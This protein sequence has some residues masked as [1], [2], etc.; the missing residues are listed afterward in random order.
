MSEHNV[1]DD[2]QEENEQESCLLDSRDREIMLFVNREGPSNTRRLV[3]L[4]RLNYSTYK[5]HCDKLV[6]LGLLK[7]DERKRFR[8]TSEAGP[9]VVPDWNEITVWE[10]WGKT[11]TENLVDLGI[12]SQALELLKRAEPRK[13]VPSHRVAPAPWDSE[14]GLKVIKEYDNEPEAGFLD[15]INDWFDGISDWLYGVSERL[16]GDF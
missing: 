7:L 16:K 14:L 1:P 15:R 11:H 5:P 2:P 6:K 13:Q 9:L 4:G 3:D 10:R 8:L 12:A